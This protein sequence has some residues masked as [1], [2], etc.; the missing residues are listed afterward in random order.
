MTNA[1]KKQGMNPDDFR[2]TSTMTSIDTTNL[3]GWYVY[4]HYYSQASY[5]NLRTS[6]GQPLSAEQKKRQP[7]RQADTSYDQSGKTTAEVSIKEALVDKK[8]GEPNA[9]LFRF[10]QHSCTYTDGKGKSNMMFAGYGTKD[11]VDFMVYPAASSSKRTFSFDMDASKIGNHTLNGAG[12][13]LNAAVEGDPTP[14]S[15]SS[16]A[17]LNGYMLYLS[18]MT[19][20]TATVGVY[21]LN[22]IDVMANYDAGQTFPKYVDSSK[23]VA[24]SNGSIPMGSKKKIRLYVDLTKDT[25]KIQYRVY[26]TDTTLNST[27]NTLY[28]GNALQINPINNVV[29][30]GFGPI[31]LYQSHGCAQMTYFPYTDLE[32]AYE[33][34]SF[35]ALKNTQYYQGAQQ[36]YFI[37]L[38]GA[39]GDATV[40][41]EQE[42]KEAYQDGIE[43]MVG[44]EIFYLSNVNDGQI[45]TNST[46]DN[47]GTAE[48]E[49]THMGLGSTNGLYATTSDYIDQMA[50]YIYENF[51]DGKP[52]DHKGFVQDSDLP[53]ANLYVGLMDKQPDGTYK[54]NSQL[55]T[56][57]LQHLKANEKAYVSM[58]DKSTRSKYNQPITKWR[59]R[60]YDPDQNIVLD[61]TLTNGAPNVSAEKDA[62]T[63]S[64]FAVNPD[65]SLNTNGTAQFGVYPIDRNSKPG[66]WLFELTVTSKNAENEDVDST[67]YQTYM[68]CFLDNEAPEITAANSSKLDSNLGGATITIVDKGQ[69][70]QADGITVVDNE[71]SGVKSYA[72]SDGNVDPNTYDQSKLEWVN[73]D[74]AKHE[75]QFT[76]DFDDY[77]QNGLMVWAKDECGNVNSSL[78]FNPCH[79][80]VCNVDGDEVSDYYAIKGKPL[81]VLPK[82]DPYM[83]IDGVRNEFGGWQGQLPDGS[84]IDITEGTLL[85]QNWVKITPIYSHD[86]GT[87]IFN[88]NGGKIVNEQGQLADTVAKELPVGTTLKG[89]A[90]NY[91]DE[92]ILKPQLL[93]YKFV[94]WKVAKNDQGELTDPAHGKLVDITNER[95]QKPTG[96]EGNKVNDVKTVYADW[97]IESYTLNYDPNG[98]TYGKVRKQTY[99]YNTKVNDKIVAL[100]GTDLPM[101]DG[102][103]FQG[104]ATDKKATTPNI[105][106]STELKMPASDLSVYAVW[107]FDNTKFRVTLKGIS[108]NQSDP[109]VGEPTTQAYLLNNSQ[110]SAYKSLPTPNRSGYVFEGWYYVAAD[111]NGDTSL[112]FDEAGHVTN[113]VKVQNGTAFTATGLPGKNDHTL[114]ANWTPVPTP[115]YIN[116]YVNTGKVLGQDADGNDYYEYTRV[117]Q[118][119]V[120]DKTTEQHA[121]L[122]AQDQKQ[123]I[124]F[125]NSQ[126]EL[127]DSY[128][129]GVTNYWLNPNA[130]AGVIET[131]DGADNVTKT[132]VGQITEGTV[133]GSPYLQLNLYYDRHFKVNINANSGGSTNA[134]D[135][136]S[137]KEGDKPTVTWMPDEGYYVSRIMIDGKIRDDLLSQTSFTYEEGLHSDKNI[138]ITFAKKN[139]NG[140]NT[141]GGDKPDPNPNPDPTPNPNP[142]NPIPQPDPEFF[143]VKTSLKGCT[144]GACKLTDSQRLPKGASTNVKLD[145]GYGYTVSGIEVDEHEY[146]DIDQLINDGIDFN[147]LV[148]D[149][150]VVVTVE[151]L[152]TIGAVTTDGQYTVTVNRYGGDGTCTVSPTTVVEPGDSPKI[153]WTAGENYVVY[154]VLVDGEDLPLNQ[155]FKRFNNIRA[156]HVV[157]IYFAEKPIATP[158]N[159]NPTPVK[160]DLDPDKNIKVTTKVVGGPGTVSAGAIL[161][162]GSDYE[163]KWDVTNTSVEDPSSLSFTNYEV[164]SVTVNGK[165]L[166][167]NKLDAKQDELTN[168][169]EDTEIVVNVKADRYN[170]DIFKY[171]E[172]TI[173]ASRILFKDGAYAGITAQAKDNWVLAKIIVDGDEKHEASYIND[174]IKFE[175]AVVQ[176]QSAATSKNATDVDVTPQGQQETVIPEVNSS[177]E[178]SEITV[179]ENNN[180]TTDYSVIVPLDP[181][182]ENGLA[183]SNELSADEQSDQVSEQDNELFNA[184]VLTQSAYADEQTDIINRNSDKT[185]NNASELAVSK[186]TQ[187]HTIEVYF[188]QK[189]GKNDPDDPNIPIV[190]P[191]PD[192]NDLAKISVNLFDGY[193]NETNNADVDAGIGY[194]EG[195]GFI[196]KGQEGRV[197]VGVPSNFTISKVVVNGKT[198]EPTPALSDSTKEGY[199]NYKEFELNLGTVNENQDIK[200]Y[201]KK[202]ASTGN[203]DKEVPTGGIE[204]YDADM[205]PI[206]TSLQGKVGII[207]GSSEVAKGANKEVSWS[208]PESADPDGNYEIKYVIVDKKP[209]P[210]LLPANGEQKGKIEFENVN[211]EHSVSVVIGEKS[212]PGE[213]PKVPEYVDIDGDGEPDIN[214]P[215]D[216]DGDG[217][218]DII[219]KK[220]TDGDGE[221]DIN[222]PADTDGDGKDD[223]ILKKDTDGDDE[224]DINIPT[225]TDGD[226]K[227]DI[228][229]KKDT[230]GDDKPDI[231]IPKDTDGDGKDDVIINRDT[232]GDDIPDVNID[233]TDDGKPDVNVDTDGDGDPDV[234]IVDKDGDG[235][236]DP[237]D[238]KKE[239]P[240]NPTVPDVN[241]VIDPETG[242]P[243]YNFD[244]PV[245]DPDDPKYH[246]TVNV[247]TD[248]D[249]KPDVNIDVDG[250]GTPDINIVDEEKN[251]KPDPIKPGTKPTPTINVDTD[252]DGIPDEGIDRNYGSPEFWQY[253]DDYLA[254]LDDNNGNGSDNPADNSKDKNDKSKKSKSSKTGDMTAPIAGGIALI[255]LLSGLVLVLARR[256]KEN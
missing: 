52:F 166:D 129:N 162:N 29:R 253:V 170:V 15:G 94:G 146:T 8:Y 21:Q 247:D 120:A 184:E 111:Q 256:R 167:A 254:G 240:K 115:Y 119:S 28:E 252:G 44:D 101:R 34:T 71:G 160:P 27:V 223:I 45:L 150:E 210:D 179:T 190:K 97:E 207:T 239:D 169:Q 20:G 23:L 57:H 110:D 69:G 82:A 36:K 25:V 118:T 116:Y 41:N 102:W 76:V 157:D 193:Q 246:P 64:T 65:A 127:S 46:V 72:L 250:D 242:E 232:D 47:P 142:I 138:Q 125:Q 67:T 80:I 75:Y 133:I 168:L 114:V 251:G 164:D 86:V 100:E 93:G 174:K 73:L 203:K 58:V 205:Y 198:V 227:D 237:V 248:G 153:D 143:Q 249:G 83:M 219:A 12:F 229:L 235:K 6:D 214:I 84:T 42:Q 14:S 26:D 161:K 134:S 60:V 180:G 154:K 217:K 68:T 105:S 244:V 9:N 85:D 215:T 95:L 171:G 49:V 128:T 10:S 3:D 255:A 221:P 18:G 16:T 148:A 145:L 92:N 196:E 236:P 226:G 233:I 56:A 33:S 172:G 176:T 87:I 50:K 245:T 159:P 147:S 103:I 74:E 11:L 218:P 149:H 225:D 182:S 183:S 122:T 35:D 151:K 66:K 54:A 177:K 188:V 137:V 107:A 89:A 195:Q 211:S 231:N 113:G 156:N 4:D 43:R 81:E 200:V 51:R 230:D 78:V 175:E 39:S 213:N 117:K 204:T 124:R 201:V 48:Q 189:T 139:E 126:Y 131:V 243:V 197:K 187:N 155:A 90:R 2:I 130:V 108:D 152:P 13:L 88:A 98:G 121:E 24:G 163:L 135:L 1:L 112:E 99:E 17:R 59:Y 241:V 216:T 19:S 37:N 70:I 220:D 234:N 222:I 22:N 209:R 79:I 224:P 199:T 104:W 5:N 30:N 186:I 38:A 132:N 144:D 91:G 62:P 192:E 136:T 32:M 206:T 173:S 109:S 194:K 40:P 181:E 208:I 212:K 53:I 178:V 96:E 55:I 31:V 123:Y 7:F 141:P 77:A 63:T 202:A 158:D 61:Q 140:G 238:P 191:L 165:E 228:I 106:T 185:T